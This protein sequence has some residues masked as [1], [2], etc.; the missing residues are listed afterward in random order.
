MKKVSSSLF[1]LALC[2]AAACTSTEAPLV[3]R[4]IEITA[5][6]PGMQMQAGYLELDN[7]T[8]G[9]ISISRIESPDFAAV[10]MHET[11]TSEGVARMR[12]LESLVVPAR[13]SVR[14]ER[15]GKHLMLK[16]RVGEPASV[17]LEFYS[18]D[19]LLLKVE[20]PVVTR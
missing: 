10:E 19:D 1:A 13:S 6:M 15:G 17:R 18:G 7:N 9:A 8:R 5:A 11:R 20:A 2:T 16:G 14:L 12:P 4:D 3:V